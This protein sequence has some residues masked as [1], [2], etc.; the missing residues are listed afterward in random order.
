MAPFGSRYFMHGDFILHRDLVDTNFFLLAVLKD[1]DQ[2]I[3]PTT[4]ETNSLFPLPPQSFPI[5]LALQVWVKTSCCKN[6]LR[7]WIC[8]LL[9][10]L[11]F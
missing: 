5:L 10:L 3:R 9:G 6:T 1:K 4:A 11:S 2:T 8:I 7:N